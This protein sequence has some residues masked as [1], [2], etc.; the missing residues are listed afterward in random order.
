MKLNLGSGG[1]PLEGYINVDRNP[2]APGVNK[3]W[4]LDVLPWPFEDGSADEVVMDQCLEHLSDHNAAMREVH[5]V[6]KPG[7]SAKISVPHFTWQLAYQDPTHKHFYGYNTFSYYA[8]ECGYF[9]FR[10]SSFQAG[11]RSR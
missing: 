10:F 1:K 7:G 11:R 8:G 5:R 9:D 6:L 2:R 4:D 3:V